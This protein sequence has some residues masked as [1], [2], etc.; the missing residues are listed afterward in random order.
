[1][2]QLI[3]IIGEV[4]ITKS[5]NNQVIYQGKHHN[6]ITKRMATGLVSFLSSY[7]NSNSNLNQSDYIPKYI[8]VGTQSSD[9]TNTPDFH[10]LKLIEEY[11]EGPEG[12][13][14]PYRYEI[15]SKEP[16]LPSTS[17]QV[18]SV[19]FRAFISPGDMKDGTIIK[20]LGLYTDKSGPT[21]LSR[22][23]IDDPDKW[24]K[25]EAGSGIDITWNILVVPNKDI[26]NTI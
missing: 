2:H 14:V 3:N 21:L 20:E 10:R 18:S 9:A 4:T 5:I 19:S 23:A 11:T 13:K 6:T 26:I 12:N 15:V 25:K 24:I 8:G 17:D 7:F 16:N 22:V 1:M